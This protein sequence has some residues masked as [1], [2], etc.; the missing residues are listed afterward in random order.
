MLADGIKS[1]LSD[2]IL[3]VFLQNALKLFNHGLSKVTHNP[4]SHFANAIQKFESYLSHSSVEVQERAN[5][6]LQC[7]RQLK[8]ARES[9][10]TSSIMYLFDGELKPV[11]AKAQKKVPIQSNLNLD[12]LIFELSDDE[13]VEEAD[14][15]E[16]IDD[17]VQEYKSKQK[18]ELLLL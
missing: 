17:L 9:N 4:E 2:D 18:S 5:V 11:G 3:V 8:E 13:V 15:E 6:G 14:S 1:H 7:I 12:E 16:A 10:S